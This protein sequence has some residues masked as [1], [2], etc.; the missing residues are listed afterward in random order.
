MTI[1]WVLGIWMVIVINFILNKILIH[2]NILIRMSYRRNQRTFWRVLILFK[3]RDKVLDFLGRY[4][5]LI[6]MIRIY[7]FVRT[8]SIIGLFWSNIIKYPA[9]SPVGLLITG[10][11]WYFNLFG[12]VLVLHNGMND[13]D[14]DVRRNM[15]VLDR[16]IISNSIIILLHLDILN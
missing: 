7:L 5:I 4:F 10:N 12:F 3:R 14:L 9:L 11:S 1:V 2:G 8:F 13:R 16:L 15:R 6:L